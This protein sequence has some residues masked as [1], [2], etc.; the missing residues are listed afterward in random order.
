MT[1]GLPIITTDCPSGPAEILENGKYGV[2]VPVG[3]SDAFADEVINLLQ[4]DD[5]YENFK[6]LSAERAMAFDVPKVA[7]KYLDCLN[8]R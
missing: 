8:L 6:R 2:L 1:C 3:D 7:E 4:H 5:Q